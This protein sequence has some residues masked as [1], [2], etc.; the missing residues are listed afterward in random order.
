MLRVK[1]RVPPIPNP[2]EFG[3]PRPSGQPRAGPSLPSR[4]L[5]LGELAA[6][7]LSRLF[8]VPSSAKFSATSSSG[9]VQ[10]SIAGDSLVLEARSLGPAQIV[11]TASNDVVASTHPVHQIFDIVVRPPGTPPNEPP[12]WRQGVPARIIPVG[13]RVPYG[14]SEYFSDPEGG[15]LTF[16]ATSDEPHRIPVTVSGNN[17]I[18][19]GKSQGDAVI[20][21][22]ATDHGGL[23]VRA[24]MQVSAVT[25]LDDR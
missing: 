6:I 4:Q 8:S 17:V 25:L 15:P 10:A 11:V 13:F 5:L 22:V 16:S 1:V 19:E 2:D 24:R 3:I 14:V 20:T 18:L 23:P 12:R 9:A 21:L 7:P